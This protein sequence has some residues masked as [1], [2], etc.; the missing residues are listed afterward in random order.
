MVSNLTITQ[1]HSSLKYMDNYA[2]LNQ[3][4]YVMLNLIYY[5]V[6]LLKNGFVPYW[7]NVGTNSLTFSSAV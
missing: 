6:E 4:M 7:P 2:F 1:N 3:I 5:M